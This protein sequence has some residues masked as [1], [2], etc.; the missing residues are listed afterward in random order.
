M[1]TNRPPQGLDQELRG[2]RM[3]NDRAEIG[4]TGTSTLGFAY[5]LQQ[6]QGTTNYE[7]WSPRQL[8]RPADVEADS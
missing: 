8:W 2:E 4:E 3:L 5:V 7:D 1:P 6:D